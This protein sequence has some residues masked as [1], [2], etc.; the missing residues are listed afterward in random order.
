M[1]ETKIE[2]TATRL[3]DG[4]ALAGY[5][6]NPWE[7]CQ[8]VG[9]G[10]DN[11]YAEARNQRFTGGTNWGPHAPRRRTSAA[12]WAKPLKWNR[13]AF[14]TNIRRNVFCASLADVMDNHASILP[15]W[16]EDLAALIIA[17]PNL[18]WLL[19]TKRIGNADH[20]LRQMFPAGVPK[21][22]WL[23]ATVVNQTEADRDIPKLL[24]VKARH[25]I[26]VAFLSMEPLLGPVDLRS[27]VPNFVEAHFCTIA[28]T[29]RG[30]EECCMALPSLDWVIVGGESGPNARPMHP[31]W[32][33]SLRDQC[34]TAGVPFFFKQWGEWGHA[35]HMKG[36]TAV[37][38]A[39][40]RKGHVAHPSRVRIH[41][42]AL[43]QHCF[44]NHQEDYH[45]LF[46]GKS[47]AGRALDGR[48]HNDMPEVTQ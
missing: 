38:N 29:A 9:P 13:E 48:E 43:D 2:W 42:G 14:Q 25:S 21:N 6:F 39:P 28:C 7:G 24:A 37:S 5:T 10:C 46:V 45:L 40:A 23:G 27:I 8:K 31:D 33:K 30:D 12:N 18:N 11:C 19:L 44:L 16:R 20:M 41:G 47:H 32:A 1:A 26:T 36:V 35:L 15:K 4:T 22:I 34:Q 17:T 3:P